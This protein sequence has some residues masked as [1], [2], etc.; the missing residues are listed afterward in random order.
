[1]KKLL[2]IEEDHVLRENT[3]EFLELSN[4]QVFSAANGKIGVEMA[5]R[6]QPDII[7]CDIFL[8]VMEGYGIF[9]SLKETQATNSIPIIFLSGHETPKLK[10]KEIQDSEKLLEPFQNEELISRIE[11]H[12]EGRKTSKRKKNKSED[13]SIKSLEELYRYFQ[14]NGEQIEVQKNQMIFREF[15]KANKVFYLDRGLVKTHR[16]DG[17]GKELITTLYRENEIFGF[18]YFSNFLNFPESATVLENCRVYQLTGLK[19]QEILEHN[20]RLTLELA[21]LLLKNLGRLKEQLLEMAYASVLKK[22]ANTIIQFAEIKGEDL[23]GSIK[24]SRSDLASIAG[25]S[26][27]SFIRSLSCLKK[28]GF[29]DIEGRNIKVLDLQK[30]REIR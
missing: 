4:Y 8:P 2:L 15:K 9:Q 21:Q 5:K 27:E 17:Y 13:F 18:Y 1:M 23:Q 6:H 12:L 28:E 26:T 25:V 7:L 10:E 29:I 22:T 20:H 30:L 24:I 19:F 11:N 14:K 3:K 16:M